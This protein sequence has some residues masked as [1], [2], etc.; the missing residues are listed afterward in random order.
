MSDDVIMQ[1][2]EP[3][4]VEKRRLVKNTLAVGLA[5]TSA[6][7]ASLV[8]MPLLIRSFGIDKYGLY[9]LASSVTAYAALLDFGAG[10]AL[11]KFV[12]EHRATGDDEAVRGSTATALS[13]YTAVGVLVA[14]VMIVIGALAQHV[15]RVDAVSAR[16]LR[17]LLWVGAI[18]QVWYWP[19]STARHVIAGL[20]RFDVLSYIGIGATVLNI[21]ATAVVVLTGEGPLVLIALTGTVTATAGLANVAYAR[22][23]LRMPVL[24]Y[25]GASRQHLAA[26]FTFSWAIFV[27]QL[28][29]ALFYQQTDRMILGI[30]AGAAAVGL[31]EAA[32]KFNSLVGYLSGLTV[33]AVL[34]L[35]SS[36]SA[37]GRHASLKSLLLRGTKYAAALVAPVAL[38][39]VVVA[40]PL[41]RAWLGSA[42]NGQGLVAQVLVFPHVLVCLGVMGDAIVISKGR[43]GGRIPYIIG[44]ALL[45]LALSIGL[46]GRYGILGVALGTSIAHLVD[47]PLHMRWLLKETDTHLAEWLRSVILPVYPLL[48]VPV[49]VALALSRTPLASSIPGILAIALLA[50]ALYWALAY[51]FSLSAEEQADVRSWAEAGFTR[52]TG[53]R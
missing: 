26:I 51:R 8:F 17:D 34:P 1:P 12:A 22:R 19:A 15:F 2:Q 4:W 25:K 20:Q 28:S 27:V 40:A 48:L 3:S 23:L 7:F 21:I 32:A 10:Q 46:V 38:V 42:F 13:F 43:L 52:L 33:S 9:M 35:A 39:L 29:D 24:S 5:Q 45:N 18:F 31:Y 37:Q 30:F 53:R 11:T 16:L 14:I 36:L 44:Q 6:M 41:I 50:L 47:F 49:A